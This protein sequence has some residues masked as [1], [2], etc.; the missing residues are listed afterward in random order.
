M[1]N[2]ALSQVLKAL[3]ILIALAGS[4]AFAHQPLWNPGSSTPLTPYVIDEISI[5]KA[6]F[7]ELT[8]ANVAHFIITVPDKLC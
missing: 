2:F 1:K 5:S 4:S 7:G 8:D 3:G 6:I